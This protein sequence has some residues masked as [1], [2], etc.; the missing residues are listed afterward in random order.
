MYMLITLKKFQPHPNQTAGESLTLEDNSDKVPI[1]LVPLK[2]VWDTIKSFLNP[3]KI[4]GC[5]LITVQMLRELPFSRIMKLTH[6]FNASFR[7]R[8]VLK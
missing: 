4:S 5:D 1:T 8:Y 7:L 2:E 3:K 6:L